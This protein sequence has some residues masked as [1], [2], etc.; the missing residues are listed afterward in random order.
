MRAHAWLKRSASDSMPFI[1]MTRTRVKAS[2]S[3]L[4]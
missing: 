3:S 1:R 4:L 2:S